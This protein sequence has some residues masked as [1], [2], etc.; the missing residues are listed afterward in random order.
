VSDGLWN[1]W[2]QDALRTWYDH[3]WVKRPNGAALFIPLKP[4]RGRANKAAWKRIRS[5]IAPH[6]DNM[7]GLFRVTWAVADV[8]KMDLKALEGTVMRKLDWYDNLMNKAY[9]AGNENTMYDG[10][11][12]M[13]CDWLPVVPIKQLQRPTSVHG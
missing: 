5:D 11:V 12:E 2:H 9:D 4:S 6:V 13:G 10:R 1:I 8:G 3:K 7:R